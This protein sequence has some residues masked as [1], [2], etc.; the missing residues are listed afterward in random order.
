MTPFLFR[1]RGV[2]ETALNRFVWE[3][4]IVNEPKCKKVKL[5]YEKANMDD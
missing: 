4:L 1:V 2:F 3:N 5:D